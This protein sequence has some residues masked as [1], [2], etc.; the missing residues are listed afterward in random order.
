MDGWPRLEQLEHS[1]YE[2]TRLLIRLI[3]RHTNNEQNDKKIYTKYKRIKAM[4]KSNL[5]F[6]SDTW[7]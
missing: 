3:D 2:P 7:P 5:C 4:T 1:E 6:F